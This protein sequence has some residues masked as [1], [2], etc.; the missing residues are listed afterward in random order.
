MSTKIPYA[1]TESKSY[2]PK[3]SAKLRKR[4]ISKSKSL[5]SKMAQQLRANHQIKET[6][7]ESSTSLQAA[8]GAITKALGIAPLDA[9]AM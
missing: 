5:Q 8:V 6:E 2:C 9:E 7:S 1:E 3:L 4:D